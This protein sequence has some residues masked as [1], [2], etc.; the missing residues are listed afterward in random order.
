MNAFKCS[1]VI[2]T[3]NRSLLLKETLESLATNLGEAADCE[4]IVV[5]NNSTDDTQTVADS[6]V[7]RL[8]NFRVFLET[9]QGL[10]YARNRGVSESFGAIIVFL[11]DDVEVEQTWLQRLIEPFVDQR[12][13]VI[14]GK[15][16]PFGMQKI[17]VWL[18]REYGFLASVFDP[19]DS[20]C[21][22]DKVMGANFAVKR[23]VFD[24]V[25]LFDVNLGRKGTK[26]LGGEE[27]ELFHRIR[28]AGYKI[29]FTPESRVW[30][31]IADKLRR[32]YIEDYAYW[33]GVSEAMIDKNVVS[34]VKYLL[35]LIRSAFFPLP[36]D[37]LK[38]VINSGDE[39]TSM[40]YMI[41]K[42][43]SRGYLTHSKAI[44]QAK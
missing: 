18:P 25:G 28:K 2:A 30:H 34:R 21:E 20:E 29:L 6:F 37:L 16:L 15:V 4:I 26:L 24:E 41:K 40:R 44:T 39:A 35:K 12:V 31:K 8:F 32:E 1:I 13:A 19:S 17:P 11:D 42:N 9:S 7:G 43:Y 10:S 38:K 23:E 14:G 3:Y 5:N 22:I 33:L 36:T 27:V